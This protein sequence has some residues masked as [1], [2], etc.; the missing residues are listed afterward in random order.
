MM[1]DRALVLFHNGKE[2]SPVIYLHWSGSVVLPLVQRVREV[3]AERTGD[4]SYT[5]ARFVG[6]ACFRLPGNCSIGVW[7]GPDNLEVARQTDPKSHG[8]SGVWLVDCRDWTV[9]CRDGYG[10]QEVTKWKADKPG[11]SIPI[12]DTPYSESFEALDRWI[13][14]QAKADAV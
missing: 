5:A 9:F 10:V 4:V 14:E 6:L 2:N 13:A 8:D 11:W 7:N 3:M 1:G 12:A